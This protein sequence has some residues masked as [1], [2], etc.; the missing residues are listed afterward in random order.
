LLLANARPP[1]QVAQFPASVQHWAALPSP[2]GSTPPAGTVSVVLA[3]ALAKPA[4]KLAA[5]LVDDWIEIVPGTVQDTSVLFQLDAPTAT[6]PQSVLLALP[7]DPTR[8]WTADRIERVVLE[9][10]ALAKERAV[11]ADLPGAPPA[12]HFLPALLFARNTGGDPDG[13]TISTDFPRTP[14]P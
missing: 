7:A 8:P 2:D 4:A 12:G 14:A 6:A 10:L 1:L 11:D 13:D 3:G 9:T 5:L